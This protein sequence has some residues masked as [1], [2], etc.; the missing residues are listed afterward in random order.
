MEIY[1]FDF[2]ID[3]QFQPWLIEVNVNPCIETTAEYL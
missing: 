1:G 3:G 2:I